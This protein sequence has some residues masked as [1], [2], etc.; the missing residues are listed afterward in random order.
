MNQSR[1]SYIY[2]ANH[3][4]DG[5]VKI[6]AVFGIAIALAWLVISELSSPLKR[7]P[8]P[9]LAKWTNWW[10]FRLVR[11]GS[12]HIHIK[13]L[14]DQYGPIL[15]IGPTLLDLDTPELVK[16]LYSSDAVWKKTDFYQNNSVIIDGKITYQLF[17]EIDPVK[18]ARMKRPVAKFFG[19]GNVLSKEIL[20]DRVIENMCN[21]LENRYQ[22]KTFDLGEWIAFCAW[23]IVGVLTFSQPFG[24]MDKG[25]DFDHSLDIADKSLDYFAA[26][27]QIPFLDYLLDKNPIMRI[28]PPNLEN[29]TRIATEHLA[30][31]LMAKEPKYSDV[32]DYLQHF[33]DVKSSNPDITETDIVMN[34]LTTLIAGA[35]TTAITIRTI[36]YY[37]LR[38][39]PVYR[40]LEEEILSA[41]MKE[42]APYASARAQPYLDATV[43]EG[44]RIHPGVCMLLERYVPESGLKLSGGNY[45][46]PGTKVGINPYVLGRNKDVWGPDADEFRPERW[47]RGETESEDAFHERMKRY[48]AADLTFGGGSRVC[49]GRYIARMEI[50]KIVATLINHFEIRLTDLESEWEV[51]GSWFPRQKGLRFNLEKRS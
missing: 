2:L 8:G 5:S 11:T 19:Q 14:H 32:P 31:R 35:D 6:V 18:H 29:V 48:S 15:R 4:L 30:K 44:M 16:T 12:Y 9:F 22:G 41:T 39:P 50:Y 34:L 23:D 3:L 33:V 51:V 37:A 45:I 24:Y 47:L 25:Y 17:S 46:P 21:H 20:M 38:N 28:G 7:Y 1:F 42:P 10:R 36:F 43:R 40:R 49:L 13:K 26:V 27:G